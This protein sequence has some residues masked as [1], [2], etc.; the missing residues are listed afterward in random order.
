[1]KI[2]VKELDL[3]YN[4]VVDKV[5]TINEPENN[6][7][8]FCNEKYYNK[9]VSKIKML[10]NCIIFLP[11]S[12]KQDICESNLLIYVD[13][14]RLEFAKLLN[15]YSL[16]E[17]NNKISIG[18]DV[19]IEDGVVLKG[20]IIIGDNTVLKSGVK[21]IGNVVI[22]KDVLIQEN[23]VIGSIALACEYDKNQKKYINIP[24]LGGVKIGNDVSI[25]ANSVVARGAIKDTF[26]GDGCKID[27]NCYISHNC[28]VGK[29]TLIVG[30]TL[31]MGSVNVGE[32][33]YI[34]GGVTVRDNLN[35]GSGVFI[36]MGSVVTRD[37][38]EN[39][40]VSGVP[41]RKRVL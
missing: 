3:N 39:M 20:N 16:E 28:I 31:L 23:S 7:V 36:A 14:P 25:G 10:K 15:K 41:A 27:S 1:M 8:I 26:I 33:S 18:K 24:Q 12:Q 19:I 17:S 40:V 22:G 2:D 9:F 30:N 11:K 6:S 13:N 35:I 38:E 29:N 4:F 34:S 5:S 32:N 21:V 37:V